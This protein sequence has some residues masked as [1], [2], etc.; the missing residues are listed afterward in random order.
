[1]T[2]PIYCKMCNL[3]INVVHIQFYQACPYGGLV[4][5]LNIF[6]LDSL[7][8]LPKHFASYVKLLLHC[9]CI[10]MAFLIIHET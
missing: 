5:M 7:S 4:C 3:Y 6:T 10:V 2:C 8:P 1:M 9:N